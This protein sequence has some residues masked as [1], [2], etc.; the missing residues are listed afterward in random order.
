MAEKRQ[1]V[2]GVFRDRTSAEQAFDTLRGWGYS[3]REINVLMSDQTRS[4][5]YP[6]AAHERHEAGTKAAEGM[7]VGGAIGTAVGAG[8]AAALAIGTSLA[9]PGLGL[10]VAGPLAAALAGGGAGAVTGGLVGAL[11]GWGIPEANA[12]AYQDALRE[13]GVV[14]GVEARDSKDAKRIE[15]AFKDLNGENVLAYSS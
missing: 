8:V 3:D 15:K 12:Q 11:V 13:G 2:S 7:A 10:V 5:Y 4:Q 6:P 9:I 14:V 1:W